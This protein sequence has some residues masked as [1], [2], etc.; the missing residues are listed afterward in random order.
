M[1]VALVAAGLGRVT[2]GFEAFTASLHQA[3]RAGAPELGLTLFQ[4]GGRADEGVVVIPSLHRADLPARWLGEFGATLVEKRS[5]ALALYPLLRRGG[6]DLVHYNEL[7]LGSALFHLRR[8]FGGR[9]R[10]LYCNGAP[11]P[12]L[13][14]HH[15]CD[16]AQLLTGPQLEEARAFGVAEARLFATPYG[17]DADRFHPSRKLTRGAV[18]REL[19]LPAAARVV[20]TVAAIKREHKRIDHLLQEAAALGPDVWVVAAGQRTADTATLE[21]MAEQLL[22]GRWRF[23]SWPHERVADLYGAA[24]VFALCSTSEAFGLVTVE[25]ML[26]EIPVVVHDGPVFR[27]LTQDA[28]VR[29]VDMGAHGALAGVLR[30]ALGPAG[31]GE[32][33]AALAQARGAAQRR[34][35]W[36]A[37]LPKYLEMYR[38]AARGAHG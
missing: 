15:R 6:F 23:L 21:V 2:R 24:D 7:T 32:R 26:S 11:S 8:L 29:L 25:A 14:Y 16:Y 33:S 30:A 1:K 9:F 31:P 10:L 35:G 3:L 12:P 17:L 28:P 18:R 13:H 34:F 36:D 37:L 22:P 19:G 4:G 27:W 5:F 38:T 20:L